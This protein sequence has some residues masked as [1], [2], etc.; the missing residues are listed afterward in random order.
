MSNNRT[1][2]EVKD[3]EFRKAV[4]CI[5]GRTDKFYLSATKLEFTPAS[6]GTITFAQMQQ[7][8]DFLGTEQINFDV[9]SSGTPDYSE[10]TPGEP[11]SRG[12]IEAFNIDWNVVQE[13]LKS[14]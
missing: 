14:G 11:G 1:F 12:Y 13:N 6:Y 3:A 9:G 8:S 10:Y 5:V 7:L 2:Y 4:E